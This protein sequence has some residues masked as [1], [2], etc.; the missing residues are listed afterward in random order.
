MKSLCRSQV[1]GSSASL[2]RQSRHHVISTTKSSVVTCNV[3]TGSL[4]TEALSP[5]QDPKQLNKHAF[6]TFQPASIW[7]HFYSLVIAD[8]SFT[9]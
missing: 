4:V 7:M 9:V 8:S 6:S 1:H 3:H 5:R 2:W